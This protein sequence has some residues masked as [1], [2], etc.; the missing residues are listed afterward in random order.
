[1]SDR[2]SGG[3]ARSF[4]KCTE[5]A[6][7]TS[8]WIVGGEDLGPKDS[9][10][11]C[12]LAFATIA[13]AGRPRLSRTHTRV[14]S[15]SYDRQTVL[16][17]PYL[18]HPLVARART[19]FRT[20]VLLLAVRA[21]SSCDSYDMP[22]K[23]DPR[24]A[25]YASA[26]TNA[27]SAFAERLAKHKAHAPTAARIN[28]RRTRQRPHVKRLMAGT[29]YGHRTIMNHWANYTQS[30]PER[31]LHRKARTWHLCPNGD[32]SQGICYVPPCRS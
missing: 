20:L 13:T 26:A 23:P 30:E 2:A 5:E 28:G 25:T 15:L 8:Y 21:L 16:S 24:P 22:A 32:R 11:E 27:P 12:E 1:M 9:A 4:Q 19:R 3:Q 18:H 6:T 7:A 17:N 31:K 29:L 14:L 10:A